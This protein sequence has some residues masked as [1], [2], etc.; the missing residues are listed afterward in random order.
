MSNRF[1]NPQDH[2]S[3]VVLTNKD[4]LF[5]RLVKPVAVTIVAVWMVFGVAIN[6][7]AVDKVAGGQA[8]YTPGVG[9]VLNDSLNDH[10][11]TAALELLLKE[12]AEQ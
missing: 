6:C 5:T 1:K 2:G 10:E 9:F 4:S 11:A 7:Q 12:R 8:T 3:H